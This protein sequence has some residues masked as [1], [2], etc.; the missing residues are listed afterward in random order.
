M[1]HTMNARPTITGRR[2]PRRRFAQ[3]CARSTPSSMPRWR[4][5][6]RSASSAAAAA[7]SSEY[8]HT[9]FVSAP[10]AAAAGRRPAARRGRSTTGRPAPGKTPRAVAR[11][12]RPA[13]GLPRLLLRP[14][15]SG[16]R[17]PSCRETFIARL[18]RL[19]D[20]LGLPWDYAPLHRSPAAGCE[21]EGRFSPPGLGTSGPR[22]PLDPRR[23]PITVRASADDGRPGAFLT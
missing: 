3:P 7:G 4:G 6:A 17:A 10:E 21:A 19:V 1:V 5:S 16:P 9:L 8:G 11:P 18:K 13:A 2:R 14:G 22:D 20:D 15:V 12:A 23:L